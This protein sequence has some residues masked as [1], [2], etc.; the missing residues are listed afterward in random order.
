MVP[1]PYISC[2]GFWPLWVVNATKVTPLPSNGTLMGSNGLI[3]W[4]GNRLRCLL[5]L[6]DSLPP[7]GVVNPFT[8]QRTIVKVTSSGTSVCSSVLSL[9]N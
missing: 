5:I 6:N 9:L 1:R 2:F 8:R 4:L 7:S 3:V